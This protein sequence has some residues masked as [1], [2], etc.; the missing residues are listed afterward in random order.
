MEFVEVYDEIRKFHHFTSGKLDYYEVI[1]MNDIRYEK[2]IEQ[3]QKAIIYIKHNLEDCE[4]IG[5]FNSMQDLRYLLNYG[6]ICK[7]E[8][9]CHI[10]RCLKQKKNKK[11]NIPSEK[12]RIEYAKSLFDNSSKFNWFSHSRLYMNIYDNVGWFHNEYYEMCIDNHVNARILPICA[13]KI[14]ECRIPNQIEQNVWEI[15]QKKINNKIEILL[16]PLV[17]SKMII[18]PLNQ[19]LNINNSNDTVYNLTIPDMITIE[20][21][22]FSQSS[23]NDIEFDMLGNPVVNQTYIENGKVLKLYGNDKKKFSINGNVVLH[24]NKLKHSMLFPI[25][26]SGKVSVRDMFPF[27]YF[28][29]FYGKFDIRNLIVSGNLVN[30]YKT[31]KIKNKVFIRVKFQKILDSII[32]CSKEKMVLNQILACE[33]PYMLIRRDVIEH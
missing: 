33:V 8:E 15:S 7:K 23:I 14:S 18:I 19:I 16:S 4:I 3:S 28:E 20:D 24:K 2:S 32:C 25:L 22:P 31:G 5:N 12:E 27:L 29:D 21:K 9:I 30:R 13:K 11:K 1:I 10:H 17:V 26:N 6:I